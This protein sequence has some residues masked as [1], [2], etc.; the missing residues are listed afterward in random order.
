MASAAMT[1]CS[2]LFSSILLNWVTLILWVTLYA[3]A[4]VLLSKPSSLLILR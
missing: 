3:G 4:Q 2:H 1:S